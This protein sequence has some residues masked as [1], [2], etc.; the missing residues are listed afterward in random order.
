MPKRAAAARRTKRRKPESE[1]SEEEEED[2]DDDDEEDD[3]E[4]QKPKPARR[5]ATTAPKR[6]P[7]PKK[8]AVATGKPVK[9]DQLRALFGDS[10]SDDG[11]N[12]AGAP[13]AQAAPAVIDED[14]GYGSDLVVDEDDRGRLNAMPELER[15]QVLSERYERRQRWKELRAI[16]NRDLPA[17]AA[18]QRGGK[19]APPPPPPPSQATSREGWSKPLKK[20]VDSESEGEASEPRLAS[21]RGAANVSSS[22]DADSF[23]SFDDRDDDDDDD[24]DSEDEEAKLPAA[25]DDFA[26]LC[27]TRTKLVDA[28]DHPLFESGIGGLFVKVNVT[29]DANNVRAYDVLR[30][31]KVLPVQK[32]YAVTRADN[33]TTRVLT[34]LKARG[35]RGSQE[36]RLDR[37]SDR[38]VTAEDFARAQTQAAVKALTKGKAA[39]LYKR[40]SQQL[41]EHVFSSEEVSEMV[42]RRA[43]RQHKRA[44]AARAGAAEA[45]VRLG[46]ATARR[47]DVEEEMAQVARDR[48]ALLDGMANLNMDDDAEAE[49][50]MADM[51][52]LSKQLKALKKELEEADRAVAKATTRNAGATKSITAK[53]NERN[54]LKN[55]QAHALAQEKR[56]A[57]KRTAKVAETIN[58]F[59]RR[60]TRPTMLWDTSRGS[61]QADAADAPPPAPSPVTQPSQQSSQ[62]SSQQ[63]SSQQSSSQHAPNKPPALRKPAAPQ[64]P[65][66]RAVASAAPS[67]PP[68]P[69]QVQVLRQQPQMAFKGPTMTFAEYQR[70]LAESQQAKQ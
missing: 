60:P 24:E 67:A 9:K 1:S 57:D 7:A 28:V 17:P 18:P 68:P 58:P 45:K 64:S 21:R 47:T 56:L 5:A 38:P 53:V 62:S 69:P 37:V 65:A 46:S 15:E 50:V 26:R 12:A 25:L 44:Q 36:V 10:D 42:A 35:P 39:A 55:N 29:R 52:V 11:N 8:A 66:V 19:R 63:S 3:E 48:Q 23:G 49:R 31:E 40:Y 22:E 61:V 59:M 6:A 51:D 2:D 70:K 34:V 20:V 16:H 41:V 54:S 30:V 14:P 43:A 33:S 4:E 13:P 32:S 27:L